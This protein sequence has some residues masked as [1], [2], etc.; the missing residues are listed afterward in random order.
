MLHFL[1]A[2][3]SRISV[4]TLTMTKTMT[5]T[6][7]KTKKKT[8]TMTKTKCLKDPSHAIFSKSREANPFVLSAATPGH[9]LPSPR[10]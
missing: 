9:P 5:K 10:K 6:N 4:M 2:G 3:S 8:K 1:K 7:A